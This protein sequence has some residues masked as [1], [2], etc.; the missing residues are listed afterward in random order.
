MAKINKILAPADMSS[1]SIS[2]V[3]MALELAQWQKS[4]VLL[5]NVITVEETPFPQGAEEWVV[6]QTEMPKVK[7]LLD[8]RKKMFDRFIADNFTELIAASSI[9]QVVD[10]GTPYKKIVEK[11]LL[12]SSDMIVMSTHGRTGLAHMLIGSVTE[13]VLRRAP[14]PVL[15]VPMPHRTRRSDKE[16]VTDD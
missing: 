5:Y 13:R 12:E 9:R 10:I 6:R 11:A 15:A 8:Q 4:E 14:C 2:G 3:R 16:P 7:K 1:L